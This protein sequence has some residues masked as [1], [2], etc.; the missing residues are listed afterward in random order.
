MKFSLTQQTLGYAGKSV[1]RDLTLSIVPG[2]KVS[3][4]GRSGAGKST[5]LKALYEQG[6]THSAL[7][8]Q[9]TALVQTLSVFHNVYMARLHV[10]P[11]WY[12]LRNLI[13]PARVEINAMAPLLQRLGL[14]HK[15][16]TAVGE[17]SGGQRQ[18]VAVARALHQ[19][20][21]VLFGDEPVSAVDERQARDVLSLICERHETVVLAMHDVEL[22]LEFS[23]RIIGL[24]DGRV[25]LD[26]P[27]SSVVS[28]DLKFLYQD[29][30][31]QTERKT[32]SADR[33]MAP[34]DPIALETY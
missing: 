32:Q 7:I 8:P 11:T 13:L 16:R 18:R 29:Q 2:E 1:L 33:E 19:D 12:N 23:D 5:L 15:L 30:E 22:A 28:S 26:K 14:E 6:Q 24:A 25:A 21:T 27:A 34:A 4:L 20:R 9:D 10:H 3:L 17:L 31:S